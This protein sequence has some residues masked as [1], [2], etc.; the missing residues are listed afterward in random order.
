MFNCG[1][2]VNTPWGLATV[3]EVVGDDVYVDIVSN[4]AETDFNVS[5]ITAYVEPAPKPE[6]KRGKRKEA[7]NLITAQ[8]T[9]DD[10]RQD[11]ADVL[12]GAAADRLV[13]Q[14]RAALKPKS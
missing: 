11:V 7:A 9:L 6:T 5:E 3:A 1:D 13:E 12:L 8:P 10:I 2:K 4:G 14:A